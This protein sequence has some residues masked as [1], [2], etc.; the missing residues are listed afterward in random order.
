MSMP[1]VAPSPEQLERSQRK[2]AVLND[3][4]S[5]K[6]EHARIYGELVDRQRKEHRIWEDEKQALEAYATAMAKTADVMRAELVQ[7]RAKFHAAMQATGHVPG[8]EGEAAADDTGMQN[9]KR[10]ISRLKETL[11]RVDQQLS[12]VLSVPQIQLHTSML[13]GFICSSRSAAMSQH[14]CVVIETQQG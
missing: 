3:L 12:E 8:S 6:A 14:E 11:D 1:P 13:H 10:E 9:L 2:Q 5:A 4:V 7:L